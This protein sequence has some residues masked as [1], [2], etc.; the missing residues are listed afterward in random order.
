MSDDH[1]LDSPAQTD[2]A[3]G[4][5]SRSPTRRRLLAL[6]ATAP[7]CVSANTPTLPTRDAGYDPP[8]RLFVQ[9]KQIVAAHERAQG[10]IDR[11]EAAL[12][13]RLGF[14]RVRLPTSPDPPL[15]YAVDTD[16]I[17]QHICRPDPP[18][19]PSSASSDV[20]SGLGKGRPECA[21]ST[22]LSAT[23]TA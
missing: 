21:V 13:T 9:F 15:L 22:P 8:A 18:H 20:D 14:P 1:F 16:T 11:I 17:D 5:G 12:V 6:L 10:R 4:S 7:V 2:T 19:V 3:G 23:R